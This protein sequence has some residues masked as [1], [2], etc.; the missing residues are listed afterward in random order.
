MRVVRELASGVDA[1]YLSGRATMPAKLWEQCRELREEAR[2]TRAPVPLVVGG[3]EFLVQGSGLGK[4]PIRL[5][6]AHGVIGLTDSNALPAIRVQPRAVAA[7]HAVGP[8][9]DVVGVVRRG[10]AACSRRTLVQRRSP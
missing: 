3:N 8:A 6:H 1:L 5:D 7:L 4:Y 9:Q 2:S 10:V